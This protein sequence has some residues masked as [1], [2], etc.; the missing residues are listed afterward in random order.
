MAASWSP[1]WD[2]AAVIV[3]GTVGTVSGVWWCRTTRRRA[4]TRPGHVYERRN[5]HTSRVTYRAVD[6]AGRRSR[7]FRSQ[8]QAARWLARRQ[9]RPDLTVV[10]PGRRYRL[11]CTHVVEVDGPFGPTT[12]RAWCEACGESRAVANGS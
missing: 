8:Q 9:G 7:K 1:W 12:G 11:E 4:R 3:L 6:G 2:V 5:L 10:D